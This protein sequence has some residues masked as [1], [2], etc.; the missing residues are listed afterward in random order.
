MTRGCAPGIKVYTFLLH[1]NGVP[2]KPALT[3][4]EQPP[5]QNPA[6]PSAAPCCTL[7][8]CFPETEQK[9]G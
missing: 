5:P 8:F 3:H 2:S 6:Q 9:L 7:G 1:Q 4:E